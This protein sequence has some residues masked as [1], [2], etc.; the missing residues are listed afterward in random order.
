[1]KLARVPT[2]FR[3]PL[4]RPSGSG[5][6]PGAQLI[7]EGLSRVIEGPIGRTPV[8]V[9]ALALQVEKDTCGIR[10]PL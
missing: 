3:L 5:L 9:R 8:Y 6:N 7:A 1:M 10:D 2:Y 4:E